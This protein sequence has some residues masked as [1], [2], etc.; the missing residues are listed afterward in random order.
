MLTLV[1]NIP[2]LIRYLIAIELNL[3]NVALPAKLS[4]IKF[5]FLKTDISLLKYK[6]RTNIRGILYAADRI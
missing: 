4:E 2:I 6:K 3:K 5:V 1:N